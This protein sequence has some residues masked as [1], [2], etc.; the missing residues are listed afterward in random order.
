M[1]PPASAILSAACRSNQTLLDADVEIGPSQL[2]G[3]SSSLDRTRQLF[4]RMPPRSF[5]TEDCI[6]PFTG[7]LFQLDEFL[8][9]YESAMLALRMVPSTSI[10]A[11]KLFT[12][13]WEKGINPDVAICN[14]II[15]QLCCTKRIPEAFEGFD[16]TNGHGCQAD[17]RCGYLQQFDYFDRT[18]L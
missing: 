2:L 14:G 15:D 5:L 8:D 4:G 6:H 16:E 12:S 17:H 18:L 13:V 1:P 3:D 9:R 10:T 7:V 11:V